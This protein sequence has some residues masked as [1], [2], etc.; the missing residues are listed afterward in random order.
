MRFIL[1]FLTT[2]ALLVAASAQTDPGVQSASRGTGVALSSVASDNGLQAFFTDGLDRFQSVFSVS[3]SP[4]NNGLGP[5]FNFNQCAGCHAFPA[6]GGSA[7]QQ[8]PQFLALGSCASVSDLSRAPTSIVSAGQEPP[9]QKGTIACSSTNSLPFITSS[10]PTVEALFPFFLNSNGTANTNAPNGQVED[11]FTVSGRPD[12]ATNCSLK[13]PPFSTAMTANDLVFRIPTPLFGLGLI[14]NLDASTL[15]PNRANN[16]NNSFGVTGTFNH[17]AIDGTITVFGWKAQGRSLQAFAGAEEDVQMG[18][19][20]L[21]FPTERA[22]QDV[23]AGELP[24]TCLNLSGTG[25]PEDY[26]HPDT[27]SG[28][29]SV[30]DD[31]SAVANFAHLLAPPVTGGVVLNGVAASAT[32]IAN[33]R[34]LFISTGCAVCHNPTIGSTLDSNITSSLSNATAAAF[35]D[36]EIHHMGVGLEDNITQSQAGSDQFRTAPLWGLGQRIFLMHDGRATNLLTAI[37][38]HSSSGS[39]ANAVVTNFN[40]L[41]ATQKQDVLNFLRSL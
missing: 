41:N 16:L 8:N 15:L 30:L 24:A 4:N 26:F 7:R 11:I 6:V 22:L 27:V 21:L 31:L 20:N 10:G 32:S 2:A 9:L 12:G 3:G 29:A 13:Q 25:Y 1:V 39:E 40:N 14:E 37:S 35:S 28:N 19:T 38:A 34:A 18:V 33:G 36:L 17:S 5:R 23:D